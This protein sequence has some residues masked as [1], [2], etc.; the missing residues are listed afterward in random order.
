MSIL[1]HLRDEGPITQ[2]QAIQKFGC[3]RLSARIY[4][5]RQ[6]GHKIETETVTG[7]EG[8]HGRYVLIEDTEAGQ[9]A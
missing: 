7:L 9:A 2:L 6:A 8:S 3:F 1:K 5:L 4:D